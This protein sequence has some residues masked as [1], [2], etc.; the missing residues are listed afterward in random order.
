MCFLKSYNPTPLRSH[1]FRFLYRFQFKATEIV[2][3]GEGLLFQQIRIADPIANV[4][5][6]GYTYIYFQVSSHTGT[7]TSERR[8]MYVET[9]SKC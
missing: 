5:H 1:T 6:Y 4:Y 7:L 8:C 2:L 3:R 9:I